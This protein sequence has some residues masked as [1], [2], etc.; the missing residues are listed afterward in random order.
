MAENLIFHRKRSKQKDAERPTIRITS[1][2]MDKIM[3]EVQS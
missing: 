3:K 1:E 2:A